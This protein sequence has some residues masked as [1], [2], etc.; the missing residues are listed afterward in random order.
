MLAVRSASEYLQTVEIF[1]TFVK[2]QC[3]VKSSFCMEDVRNSIPWKKPF[4][5][6]TGKEESNTNRKPERAV[7]IS[8][9]LHFF[10][11]II[12]QILNVCD[13]MQYVKRRTCSIEI[14]ENAKLSTTTIL[15]LEE[16]AHPNS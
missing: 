2:L 10:Q 1:S 14:E 12:F 15:G 9:H 5:P 6:K 7:E 16:Y 8:N 13:E 4:I 3:N 11:A